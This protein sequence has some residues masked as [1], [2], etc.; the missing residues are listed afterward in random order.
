MK[1]IITILSLVVTILIPF[2]SDAV[3]PPL[4]S[5]GGKANSSSSC[6]CSDASWMMFGP[7]HLGGSIMSGPMAFEPAGTKQS[8]MYMGG[9]TNTIYLGAYMPAVQACWMQA[10][11]FCY[12]RP[13][14]GVM[15]FI[16]TQKATGK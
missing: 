13:T 15:S 10:T 1:K 9:Q 8:S 3:S 16:G 4:L 6:T 12:P 11:Y 5:F 7:L 14:I 2:E